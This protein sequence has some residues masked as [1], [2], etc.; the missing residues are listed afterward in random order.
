MI[1]LGPPIR[2]RT[3]GDPALNPARAA[4]ALARTD[5]VVLSRGAAAQGLTRG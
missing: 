1:D 2:L 4:Q 5:E 3:A